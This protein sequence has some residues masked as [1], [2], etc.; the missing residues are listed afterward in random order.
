[1]TSGAGGPG[2][3][4]DYLVG[5]ALIC[6]SVL[7]FSFLDTIAKYLGRDLPVMQ[8]VWARYM[9][10]FLL[11]LVMVAP[12]RGMAGIR[13]SRIGIQ[14]ARSALL[15]GS[16][17][18]NFVALRYLQLTETVSILFTA[19]LLVAVFS[20]FLLGEHVG[21]RRWGAIIVGFIGVLIITRPGSG[22]FQWPALLSLFSA[23]SVALY[24]ILTR[25]LAGT[26]SAWTAQFYATLIACAALT[27]AMPF[28]WQTPTEPIQWLLLAAI[29]MFGGFGHWIYTIAHYRAP[30]SHI[31]PFIYSQIVWMTLLGYVVFS[32]LP[33]P[34]TAV[35]AS[36]VALSGLY[37]LR[38][39][40]VV[41]G[42]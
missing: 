15:F 35:G 36:V 37:L 7:C 26:D 38:R 34:W 27:P 30:A 10:H 39:Q 19:P 2:D 13:T 22:A 40:R 31:A 42:E 1:M 20:V 11:A 6:G 4:R 28:V 5:I 32:D 33:G 8:I 16:T 12:W 17:A 3:Y 21:P 25:K 41:K 29:G 24:N 14:V 23:F 9:G 18:A